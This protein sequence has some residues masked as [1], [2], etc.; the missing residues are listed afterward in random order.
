M[1]CAHH[2]GTA[3]TA[4]CTRCD[5]PLCAE[6]VHERGGRNFCARCA[7]FL[8]RRSSQRPHPTG[9]VPVRP[10]SPA[11][12]IPAP[13]SGM[14]PGPAAVGDV[15][16]GEAPQG[17]APQGDVYQGDVYQG[18]VYQGEAPQG[19]AP[20]SSP[21]GAPVTVR[22]TEEAKEKGSTGRAI[23]F[24]SLVG[25]FSAVLWY[26]AVTLTGYQFGFLAIIIGWLVGV[27]TTAGAG[28]GGSQ[29]AVLSLGIAAVS[30]I[31]GDYMINDHLYRKFTSLEI[32][33]EAAFSDGDISDEDIALYLETSVPE[34]RAELSA[35]ELEE[36]R[37]FL[38]EE[39]SGSSYD[40]DEPAQ[41]AHL[42]LS[43]LPLWMEWWEYVFIAIGAFQAFRVPVSDEMV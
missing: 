12:P 2:S 24:G 33:E 7:E 8:D 32:Q 43:Q 11:P 22:L 36:L 6:C 37:D 31:G 28:G 25:L 40:L 15:Y 35:E 17:E 10:A 16:Q 34:L 14:A 18:D 1:D 27:A 39:A 29:V 3:A 5:Q 23:L 41:P 19:E 20:P 9:N 21:S 13:A 4:I 30:M 38:E 42:P 26:G